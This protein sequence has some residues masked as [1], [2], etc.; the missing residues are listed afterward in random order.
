MRVGLKVLVEYKTLEVIASAVRP[1]WN[2]EVY[3]PVVKRYSG[4]RRT[5]RVRKNFIDC[6]N[7]VSYP[8]FLSICAIILSVDCMLMAKQCRIGHDD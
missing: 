5:C 7:D 4:I 1:K 2:E 3:L 8:H 6:V